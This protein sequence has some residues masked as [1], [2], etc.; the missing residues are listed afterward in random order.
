MPIN[1][2][3]NREASQ[4]NDPPRKPQPEQGIAVPLTAVAEV[5]DA[6]VDEHARLQDGRHGGCHGGGGGGGGGRRGG[7]RRVLV[8]D[9]VVSRRSGG[10][11]GG[12]VAAAEEKAR[13]RRREAGPDAAD[14]GSGEHF[15]P[16]LSDGEARRGVAAVL[17][18]RQVLVYFFFPSSASRLLLSS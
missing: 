16:L 15:F 4:R 7:A 18:A 13:E 11:G 2:S 8:D 12:R 1:R 10:G 6:V 17:H 9:K 5:A 3:P 14:E